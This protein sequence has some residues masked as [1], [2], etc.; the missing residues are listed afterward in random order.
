MHIGRFSRGRRRFLQ[1]SLATAG[2]L[3]L[4]A[5]GLGACTTPKPGLGDDAGSDAGPRGDASTGADAGASADAGAKPDSG[6]APGEP[7]VTFSLA[8]SLGGTLLPWTLGHFFHKGDVPSGLQLVADVD[9]FQAQVRNRWPDG[10]VKFAV[11]SGRCDLV[12]G[13]PRKVT[14]KTAAQAPAPA[15]LTESD[16][17]AAVPDL[18]V[19]VG[20]F[21]TVALATALGQPFRTL[22]SGPVASEWQ[23]RLPVDDQLT[24]W[25]YVRLYK[26]GRIECLAG[27][28]NGWFD[29]TGAIN[30]PARVVVTASGQTLYDSGSDLDLKHHTRI[31]AATGH[32]GKV[33][34][35]GDPAV[36]P[37]HDPA[38][39][40]RSGAVPA[41]Q[42]QGISSK[43]LDALSQSYV[44]FA[45]H[46]LPGNNLGGGGD[47]PGIGWLPRWDACC[48]VSGDAR[49]YRAVLV[50]SLAS[51]AWSYHRRER[52]TGE[53]V[54]YAAHPEERLLG[55][56]GSDPAYG[57]RAFYSGQYGSDWDIS[58]AW[59]PGYL[60]YVLTGDW[61][62][63]E[64]LHFAVKWVHYILNV[65]GRDHD[66]GR[67]VR[68]I[69]SRGTGWAWRNCGLCAAILPDDEPE[70]ASLIRALE[71]SFAWMPTYHTNTLGYILEPDQYGW[72]D[73]EGSR[74]WM[75]DYVTGSLAWVLDL[76]LFGGQGL[77]DAESLMTW[78]G[79]GLVQRMSD[80]TNPDGWHW[81]CQIGS[82]PISAKPW[83]YYQADLFPT[84]G[85]A[86]SATFKR[87]NGTDLDDAVIH[88]MNY[89]DP[90][91]L[92]SW[93]PK[94]G[95]GANYFEYAMSALAAC[96]NRG[97]AGA[98]TAFSRITSATNYAQ[99]RQALSDDPR[100]GVAPRNSILEAGNR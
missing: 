1:G 77:A 74:P 89:G 36:V 95:F 37:G 75:T 52:A 82:P 39:L 16:L 53:V 99:C 97:V 86:F 57:G 56:H 63:L 58:H 68:G 23:Y 81:E 32:S 43:T 11:L 55:D 14:L 66:V 91:N 15:A 50:N 92:P 65:E 71:A 84:W 34:L 83:P 44:P 30:K 60:A 41:F 18:S 100:W 26:G 87:A 62:H 96:V 5:L 79:N 94:T 7:I 10:S 64:E 38:Y 4:E 9:E 49:A 72:G 78:L 27:V 12:G 45:Q 19:K 88:E 47:D 67:M 13:T 59:P 33:W 28:E 40:Q 69:Q 35:G 21:G 73:P 48:V 24:V 70:R 85:Q 25:L 22:L 46:D 80:G 6:T 61:W 20:G 76:E 2:A 54:S 98:A 3:G 42:A 93:R 17:I 90:T 31:A 51:G 8:S 29:Y